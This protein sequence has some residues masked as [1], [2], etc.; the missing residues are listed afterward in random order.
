MGPRKVNG[1]F[2]QRDRAESCLRLCQA[3][4]PVARR[5]AVEVERP[6]KLEVEPRPETRGRQKRVVVVLKTSPTL[7]RGTTVTW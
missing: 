6:W 2:A 7:Y 4:N 5:E 3:T 1:H